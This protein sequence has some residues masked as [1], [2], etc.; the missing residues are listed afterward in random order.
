MRTRGIKKVNVSIAHEEALIEHDP[1]KIEAGEI[2]RILR[3]LVYTVRDPR[4]I[5]DFEEEDRILKLELPR[6]HFAHPSLPQPE[7]A[8][9]KFGIAPIYAS[10]VTFRDGKWVI[11]DEKFNTREAMFLANMS[12]ILKR[13]QVDSFIPVGRLTAKA[14]GRQGRLKEMRPSAGGRKRAVRAGK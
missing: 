12:V 14:C 13:H 5:Q 6:I 9:G 11:S 3:G 2:K 8:G 7:E 1:E 4:K 10:E